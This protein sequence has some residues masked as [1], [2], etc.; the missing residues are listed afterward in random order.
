MLV[1]CFMIVIL[2]DLKGCVGISC[3]CCCDGVLGCDRWV[4]GV[5]LVVVCGC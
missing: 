5:W 4:V 1:L 3:L 2:V